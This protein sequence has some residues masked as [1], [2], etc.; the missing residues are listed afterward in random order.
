MFSNAFM[1]LNSPQNWV[2]GHA[3]KLTT[4]PAAKHVSHERILFQVSGV[5]ET[6]IYLLLKVY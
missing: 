6:K 1:L 4:T 3:T 5:P 2:F